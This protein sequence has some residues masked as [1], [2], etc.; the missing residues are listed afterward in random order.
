MFD[1][2]KDMD[3]CSIDTEK[4]IQLRKERGLS[5]TDLANKI[6]TYQAVISWIEK[7]TKSP[8]FFMICKI[9]TFFKVPVEDLRKKPD[10]T[11]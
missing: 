11:F 6:G 2:N 9:A 10:Y 8:S 7:K 1:Q 3:C 4:I 5:Q